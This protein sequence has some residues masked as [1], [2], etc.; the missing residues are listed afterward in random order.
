MPMDEAVAERYRRNK[1]EVADPRDLE[2]LVVALELAA[3]SLTPRRGTTFTREA[4]FAEARE[5]C[6]SECELRE[7]DLQLVLPGMRCLERCSGGYR[8]R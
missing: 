4:L 1:P 3:L 8:L 6:G 7:F 5:I 2:T